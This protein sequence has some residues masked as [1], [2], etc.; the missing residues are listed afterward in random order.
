MGIVL[1]FG[2]MGIAVVCGML[3]GIVKAL[4]HDGTTGEKIGAFLL[5]SILWGVGVF[6]VCLVIGVLWIFS[7]SQ[8]R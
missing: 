5:F 3:F 4:E 8:G 2:S 7:V 1:F 6:I